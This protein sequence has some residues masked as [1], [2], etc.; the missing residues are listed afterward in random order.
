[1]A[2]NAVLLSLLGPHFFRHFY[3]ILVLSTAQTLSKKHTVGDDRFDK[4]ELVET[5]ER[6]NE[7]IYASPYTRADKK[8]LTHELMDSLFE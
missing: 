1:M 4:T 8:A 2:L 6:N 3:L 5:W 7:R